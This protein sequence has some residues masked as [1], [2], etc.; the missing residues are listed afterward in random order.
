MGILNSALS[1]LPARGSAVTPVSRRDSKPA[2]RSPLRPLV[3]R[4][5]RLWLDRLSPL[6]KSGRPMVLSLV[7]KGGSGK[8]TSA[9]FIATIAAWLGHSVW[10]LDLDPQA[11]ASTWGSRR[12]DPGASCTGKVAVHR[13]RSREL[14]RALEVARRRGIDL[15]VIDNQ[16]LRHEDAI[17]IARSADLVVTTCGPTLFDVE[18]THNWLDF[19][20]EHGAKRC[21]VLGNAPPR[22]DDRDA[23]LVAQARLALTRQRAN[24][25]GGSGPIQLW[26]GQVTRRHAVIWAVARGAASIE[27]EPAGASA[28]E[29]RGLWNF[30]AEQLK[31]VR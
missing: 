18:A 1:L 19:L 20:R 14:P 22:K 28:A 29:F 27:T 12:M 8:S 7:G 31:D 6:P 21:V 5:P 16:P 4:D 3:P 11:S 17:A 26:T 30:L 25:A 24:Q 2:G 13:C 15:V 10:V 9:V 23:P